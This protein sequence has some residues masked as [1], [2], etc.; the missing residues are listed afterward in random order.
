MRHSAAAACGAASPAGVPSATPAAAPQLSNQP[1]QPAS[2]TSWPHLDPDVCAL[3]WNLMFLYVTVS[4]LKPMVGMVCTTSPT[5]SRSAGR[6]QGERQLSGGSNSTPVGQPTQ[7][8]ANADSHRVLQCLRHARGVA[9]SCTAE[10]GGLPLQRR[11]SAAH[12]GWWSC[13]H[14]PAPAPAATLASAGLEHPWAEGTL[15]G[16][17]GLKLGCPRA[18]GGR[19]RHATAGSGP[20]TH[21]DARLL[22]AKQ[23]EQPREP[24]P[25]RNEGQAATFD[26]VRR[27]RRRQLATVRRTATGWAW[28]DRRSTKAALRRSP[29]S[30]RGQ[31]AAGPAA[32]VRGRAPRLQLGIVRCFGQSRPHHDDAFCCCKRPLLLN[33]VPLGR[34]GDREPR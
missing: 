7:A 2:P 17:R 8:S 12:T 10:Q 23:A 11:P 32:A 33:E 1:R 21:Q 29:N 24:E 14:C 5:C 4:T 15:Q 27:R 6:K 13:P 28:I 3:T 26:R 31:E 19:P 18:A 16:R 9:A 20:C 30:A 34:L 22:V 25:L